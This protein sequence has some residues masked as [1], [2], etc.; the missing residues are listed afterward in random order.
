[1]PITF[2]QLFFVLFRK[3]LLNH[4]RNRNIVKELFGVFIVAGLCIALNVGGGNGL[5]YIPVYMP[6]ALMLFCRGSVLTWVA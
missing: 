2:F 5:Q 1:M 4:I 3:H 6:L